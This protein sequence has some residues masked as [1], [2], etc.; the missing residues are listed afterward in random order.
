MGEEGAT[1]MLPSSG[2]STAALRLVAIRLL[3]EVDF[4]TMPRT[5]II[6]ALESAGVTPRQFREARMSTFV[7]NERK[8]K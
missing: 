6:K 1:G 4:K 5:D 8:K 7:W 2:L 3:P